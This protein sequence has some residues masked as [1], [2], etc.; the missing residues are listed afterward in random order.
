MGGYFPAVDFSLGNDV[1]SLKTIDPNLKSYQ[2]GKVN[3]K[4]E[5]YITDLASY[6]IT[7]DGNQVNKILDVRVPRGT[8]TLL[9]LELLNNIA[10][11]NGISL[12]IK[13]L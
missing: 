7:I 9:D 1:V 5:E 8:K 2:N 13:E 3:D 11:E 12:I 4:I 6:N 10:E